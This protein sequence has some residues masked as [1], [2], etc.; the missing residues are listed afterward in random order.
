MRAFFLGTDRVVSTNYGQVDAE[1]GA[2]RLVD[3]GEN[4]TDREP[5]RRRGG[6]PRLRHGVRR[7]EQRRPELGF[8]NAAWD[9]SVFEDMAAGD[10]VGELERQGLLSCYAAATPMHSLL[11]PLLDV[12]F[13]VVPAGDGGVGIPRTLDGGADSGSF[14]G[15]AFARALSERIIEPAR[16]ADALLARWP[17][18]TRLF[19]TLSPSEM[20]Q[21]PF[22][23]ARAGLPEMTNT[24]Q[25]ALQRIAESGS[26]VTLPGG[27]EVALSDG[28]W[29]P[30]PGMPAAA[31][32]EQYAIG[33]PVTVVRNNTAS[34]D[35]VLEAWNESRNWPAPPIA[36]GGAGG[37]P[38]AG[39]G[40]TGLAASRA[41]AAAR[42]QAAGRAH[43][44][45]RRQ[46]LGGR[47]RSRGAARGGP[48]QEG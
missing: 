22:F 19:T 21:V 10:V 43:A 40:A 33:R 45:S 2:H 23:A 1:P 30:F 44:R 9:A 37:A 6:G 13:P 27:A 8:A 26:G 34:I 42:G 17:Y 28:A 11:L 36:C 35:A 32:I 18:L 29:P 3:D 12:F 20:T 38:G 39:R 41:V 46:L 14:D 48:T 7:A 15:Q 4:T 24:V 25:F 5:G 31:R 16:H 47:R